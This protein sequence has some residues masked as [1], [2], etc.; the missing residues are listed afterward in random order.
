MLE[1][2]GKKILKDSEGK[3]CGVVAVNKDGE[4]FTIEC[5]A[6]V[7]ATG[8]AGC[9][10]EFIKE[11]TGLEQGKDMFN[12][13]I[14]GLVGDGLKMAW[15]AGADHLPVRIEQACDLGGGEEASGSVKNVLRQPNLI[16]NKF[17]KR[18]MPCRRSRREPGWPTHCRRGRLRGCTRELRESPTPRPVREATRAPSRRS[19]GR[20]RREP[21]G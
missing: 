5:K 3:V 21:R 1:T 18:V 15:E 8:G 9:N 19:R 11:E 14:P 7:I 16:V 13:A 12:F 4:E 17:G 2:S 20:V 6:A 10:K